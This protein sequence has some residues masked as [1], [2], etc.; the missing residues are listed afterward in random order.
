MSNVRRLKVENTLVYLVIAGVPA[1]LVLVP[2]QFGKMKAMAK[3]DGKPFRGLLLLVLAFA[4]VI[5]SL[6]IG[7]AVGYAV[8]VGPSFVTGISNDLLWFTMLPALAIGILVAA[9]ASRIVGAV[10][11]KRF[12]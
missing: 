1:L 3:A 8:L 11:V 6:V 2:T 4:T 5:S 9:Y 10:M 12:V 7:L